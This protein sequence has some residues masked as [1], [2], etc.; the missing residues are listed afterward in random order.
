MTSKTIKAAVVVAVLALAGYW[1]WS[2]FLAVS[3]LQSAAQSKDADSFNEHVDYPKVRESLK[4]QLSAFFAERI[5]KT[6]ESDNPLSALGTMVGMAMVNQFVDAM[7]RPEMVMQAM[8]NG[9]L[10]P[11]IKPK[12]ES[13]PQEPSGNSSRAENSNSKWTYERKGTNKLIAYQIDPR[14]PDE[15]TRGRGGFVFERSGFADWKLT[16]V[17]LPAE[18]M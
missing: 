3:Q 9:K 8:R 7:V 6:T 17:R 5:G 12:S 4:G 16:E 14:R 11:T 13:P 2:P 15:P 18:D 1:Y 10:E